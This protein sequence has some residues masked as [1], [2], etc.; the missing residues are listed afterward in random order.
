MIDYHSLFFKID[1]KISDILVIFINM[2]VLLTCLLYYLFKKWKLI[3]LKRGI[4]SLNLGPFYQINELVNSFTTK[5]G[6]NLSNKKKSTV[7][8]SKLT[9]KKEQISC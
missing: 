4:R 8:T 9:L 6:K 2:G 7:K 5:S 1:V 3:Y